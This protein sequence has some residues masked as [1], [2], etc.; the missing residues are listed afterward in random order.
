MSISITVGFGVI[1]F[2]ALPS[3]LI[4]AFGR[5][6]QLRSGNRSQRYMSMR[7]SWIPTAGYYAKPV[8]P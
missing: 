8:T 1:D 3:L 4:T 7:K 2:P 5:T 6:N